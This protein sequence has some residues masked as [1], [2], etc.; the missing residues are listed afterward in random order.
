M[1][2]FEEI[3]NFAQEQVVRPTHQ[4]LML[5]KSA[6]LQISFRLENRNSQKESIL[7]MERRVSVVAQ[8]GKQKETS[9]VM[10]YE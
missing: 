10:A 8:F 6:K 9:L 1:E 5:R 4:I 2:T 7:G 3:L